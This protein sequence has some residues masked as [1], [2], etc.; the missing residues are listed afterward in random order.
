VEVVQD[1]F[2]G[3]Y[4]LTLMDPS[5]KHRHVSMQPEL[6]E[7]LVTVDPAFKQFLRPN[8]SIILKMKNFIYGYK[9][10][11]YFWYY[12][13]MSMF[14]KHGY[15]KSFWDPC[16]LIKHDKDGE[17]SITVTIDDYLCGVSSETVKVEIIEMC[18]MEF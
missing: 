1:H 7:A 5:V 14:I 12:L 13:L 16:L 6:A 4:H 10:S 17:R 18:R 9:E 11:G 8:G 15:S 3:A 2:T